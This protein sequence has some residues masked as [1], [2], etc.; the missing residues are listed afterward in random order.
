MRELKEVRYIPSITK[1]II[2][3]R[4]LEAEGL[5]GTLGEGVLKMSRGLLVV[6]KDSR[7]NKV[8]YLMG[9]VVTELASSRQLDGNSIR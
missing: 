2:S 7:C 4:V 6:L 5:R 1:N 3:V 9:S 8:Y